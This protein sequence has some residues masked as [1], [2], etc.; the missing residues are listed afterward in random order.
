V[1]ALGVVVGFV[2]VGRSHLLPGAFVDLGDRNRTAGLGH[3]RQ[4]TAST[5]VEKLD[6]GLAPT[7]AEAVEHA[8]LEQGDG[9]LDPGGQ[10]IVLQI[11]GH[12]TGH[13]PGATP[14]QEA[15]RRGPA[16]GVGRLGH[17]LHRSQLVWHPFTG[18]QP[19]RECRGVGALQIARLGG[20]A[21]LADEG[22]NL[23]QA[24]QGRGGSGLAG[25]FRRFCPFLRRSHQVGQRGVEEALDLLERSE[26][27]APLRRG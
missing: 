24:N 16:E 11:P 5:G 21:P 15:R 12:R 19:P 4:Q 20:W 7:L 25:E 17:I 27:A 18:S 8:G 1:A 2:G 23:A 13:D 14:G 22:H 9:G 3:G 10:G 26:V 6:V